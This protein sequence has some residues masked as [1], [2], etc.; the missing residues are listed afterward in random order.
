MQETRISE[1]P[2]SA[3]SPQTASAGASNIIIC[4]VCIAAYKRPDLLENLLTSLVNQVLPEDVTL[5]IIVVDNDPEESAR[6]VVQKFSDTARARFLYC[7]QPIKNISLTR[8]LAVAN[9]TG[10]YLLFIDDDETAC[11]EW[12]ARLLRALREFDADGV[13]G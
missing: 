2:A 13:F 3:P 8:N 6:G 12:V 7:R 10:A 9:A 1:V 11:R 5:E 4:S